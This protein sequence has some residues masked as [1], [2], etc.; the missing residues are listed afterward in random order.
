MSNQTANPPIIPSSIDWTKEFEI[1]IDDRI[2]Y[3]T[4]RRQMAAIRESFANVKDAAL[5]QGFTVEEWRDVD[6]RCM[7]ARFTPPHV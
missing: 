7:V 2:F 6:K 1:I 4:T 5:Q 3:T